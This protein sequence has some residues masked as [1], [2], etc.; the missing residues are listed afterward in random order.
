MNAVRTTVEL[1]LMS[2][3]ILEDDLDWDI[4]LREQMHA[5]ALATRTLTQPLALKNAT[6]YEAT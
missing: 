1:D 3:I 4:R 6:T 2:A 5:I